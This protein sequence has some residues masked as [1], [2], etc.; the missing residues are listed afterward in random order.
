MDEDSSFLHFLIISTDLYFCLLQLLE[1]L[2]FVQFLRCLCL[3]CV[4]FALLKAYLCFN[5]DQT[6]SQNENAPVTFYRISK[7]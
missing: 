2:F 5:A 4:F 3:F 6:T 1:N 7:F